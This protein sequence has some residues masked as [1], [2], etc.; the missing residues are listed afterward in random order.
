ALSA[1]EVALAGQQTI[2]QRL[3]R[4]PQAVVL[5]EFAIL[6]DQDFLDQVRMVREQDPARAEAGGDKIAVFPSPT[7]Q[8]TEPVGAEFAEVPEEPAGRRAGRSL[9][10][11][12]G[13]QS[14][15]VASHRDAPST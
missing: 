6:V 3:L 15:A 1:P 4:L 14:R 2:P 7:R 5:D 9:R 10:A 13:C 11:R 8:G 12:R